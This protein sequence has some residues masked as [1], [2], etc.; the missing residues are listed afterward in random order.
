MFLLT[1]FIH[2]LAW[3]LIGAALT[4]CLF[5]YR[6][7]KAFARSAYADKLQRRTIR[8]LHMNKQG[9]VSDKW[10][11]YL[12]YYDA[13]FEPL[14][15][16]AI[17]L[18]EIG[19]Q[20]GGSLEVWAAYFRN[21]RNILGCDINPKCEQLRYDDPRINIIVRDA[22]LA[23]TINQVQTYGPFDV[24][25]D[26]G[27]HL[28]DDIRNSFL[29]YFPMLKPGGIYVVEDMHTLFNLPSHGNLDMDDKSNVLNLFQEL[30]NTVN[31]QFW[32]KHY[33]FES[34]IT[35][36]LNGTPIPLFILEGWVES[37]EFRNSII[38]IRKALS[39]DHNKLGKRFVFG[40]VA[41]VD[42]SPLAVRDLP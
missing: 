11:S 36:L 22:N 38:T 9:K 19:I 32:S 15:D 5:K 27:S 25:I 16:E 8:E 7:L 12:N 13:L 6:E 26:D 37:V 2:A 17:N 4:F 39:P 34:R 14:K 18:F 1:Q 35:P 28:S 20:N 30:T 33:D 41:A 24:I 21:A 23:Q 3:I 31:Y 10:A 42:A 40:D 29:S